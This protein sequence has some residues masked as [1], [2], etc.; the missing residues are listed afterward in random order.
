M[1][2]VSAAIST[3]RTGQ[4]RRMQF[5]SDMM[6]PLLLALALATGYLLLLSRR[7]SPATPPRQTQSEDHLESIS[8]HA[9]DLLHT[10]PPPTQKHYTVIGGSGAVGSHLVRLLLRRGE[11]P[12]RLTVLDTA[13]LPEELEG[14]GVKWVRCDITDYEQV[15]EGLQGAQVVFLT[16]AAIRYFERSPSTVRSLLSLKLN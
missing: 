15:R 13:P 1:D 10:V 4:T 14:R 12:E 9:I 5:G 2:V 16:A 7:L 6:I 11:L 8:Y 3:R